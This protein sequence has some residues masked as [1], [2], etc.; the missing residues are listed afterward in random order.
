MLQFL[1]TSLADQ[2]S[3]RLHLSSG[4]VLEGV[5]ARLEASVAELRHPDGSR[6]RV[7]TAHIIA[8]T[9]P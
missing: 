2:T 4:A 1:Q 9:L 6:T 3:L 7:V 8:A 5:V